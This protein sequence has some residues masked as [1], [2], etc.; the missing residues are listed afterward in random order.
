MRHPGP[1]AGALL[2]AAAIGYAQPPPIPAEETLRYTINWPSGLSLGEGLLNAARSGDRWTFSLTLD[3]ALPGFAVSDRYRSVANAGLCALEAEKDATHGKRRTRERTV[4][5]HRRGIARRVTLKGGKSEIPID[6]CARDALGFLFHLRRE[7]AHG[8]VPPPQT[9]LFGAP[10]HVRLEYE[11]AQVV[12]VNEKPYEADRVVIYGKGPA[13][14]FNFEIFFGRD[15][16]RT[17]LVVRVP[18]AVGIFSMEL[19]R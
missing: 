12:T 17:P 14:K 2:L 19:A 1:I 9:V 13:S 11:G 16:A 4:F 5:N 18:F 6:E 10:Y 7:L 15:A 8:R 3:A